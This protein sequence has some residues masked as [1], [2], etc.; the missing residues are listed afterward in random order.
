MK[1]FTQGDIVLFTPYSLPSI[2]WYE[3]EYVKSSQD[4]HEKTYHQIKSKDGKF[5]YPD[6]QVKHHPYFKS[7]NRGDKVE[8]SLDNKTWYPAI[9]K[10][11]DYEDYLDAGYDPKDYVR[12]IPHR[13][14][15]KEIYKFPEAHEYYLWFPYCRDRP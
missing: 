12:D 7:W 13:V 3:G 10:E 9:Y 4:A 6:N 1:A 11:H 15:G 2:K 5:Y 14:M 8:V